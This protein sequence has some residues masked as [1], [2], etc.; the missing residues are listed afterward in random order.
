MC[1]RDINDAGQAVGFSQ[2]P[3]GMS[4]AFLYAQR[5]MTNLGTLPGGTQSFAHG[6]NRN[7]QVVGASDLDGRGLRAFIYDRGQM[8]DLNSQIPASSGWTLTV[9]RGINRNGQIVGEG[10]FNNQQRAF[11]LTPR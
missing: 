10:V 1:I 9:A 2:L 6:I 11:F 4:R 5:R 3:G 7:G 8:T